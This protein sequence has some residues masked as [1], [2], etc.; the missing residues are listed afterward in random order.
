MCQQVGR[1]ALQLDSCMPLCCTSCYFV[2]FSQVKVGCYTSAKNIHSRLHYTNFCFKFV[3]NFFPSPVWTFVNDAL[4]IAC[5]HT[6]CEHLCVFM[7]LYY[8]MI[9]FVHQYYF[10]P[11]N[12]WIDEAHLHPMCCNFSFRSTKM[13]KTM[14]ANNST[15][16]VN[17][18]WKNKI[19]GEGRNA[20]WHY[21]KQTLTKN[22]IRKS[23]I[24][25]MCW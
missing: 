8:K 16:A 17:T 19:G 2:V 20:H 21:L 14:D 6:S 11:I 23:Y 5:N 13:T 4:D 12:W 22:T 15:S 25:K 3:L 24:F 10:Y 9:L 1:V 7:Y 18:D